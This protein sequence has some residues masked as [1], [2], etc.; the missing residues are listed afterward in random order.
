M[1]IHQDV[2]NALANIKQ[3]TSEQD[4]K[5]SIAKVITPPT[6]KNFLIS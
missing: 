5:R 1:E 2:S 3:K 4:R 6:V